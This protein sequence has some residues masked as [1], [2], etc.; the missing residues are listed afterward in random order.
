MVRDVIL[1]NRAVG[2]G[3]SEAEERAMGY[4][5]ALVQTD[6]EGLSRRRAGMAA[7]HFFTVTQGNGQC[8]H[9]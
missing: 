7:S 9:G 1:N 2:D 3:N 8:R 6:R 4:R 5:R